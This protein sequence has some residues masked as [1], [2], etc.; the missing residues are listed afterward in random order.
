[1]GKTITACPQLDEA[2]LVL[3]DAST[4][5]MRFHVF[6]MIERSDFIANKH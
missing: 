6:D 3:N 2:L 5:G 4:E 1:M